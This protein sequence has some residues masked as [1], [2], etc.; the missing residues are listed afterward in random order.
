MTITWMSC[1]RAFSSS[2]NTSYEWCPSSRSNCGLSGPQLRRN[3]ASN[4]CSPRTSSIHA[5]RWKVYMAPSTPSATLHP[6]RDFSVL[7]FTISGGID[8]PIALTQPRTDMLCIEL[9][10]LPVRFLTPF[11][12]TT[13]VGLWS[14]LLP[15]SS[16][17][18]TS[19]GLLNRL[20]VFRTSWS[21]LKYSPTVVGFRALARLSAK[22][23]GD[24]MVSS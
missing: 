23:S 14:S 1:T 8:F 17:L 12:V 13:L 7:P 4:H 24:L 5:L 18:H 15:V 10:T 22:A 21:S 19:A 11:R 16:M 2:P 20:K 6:C 3:I 9:P